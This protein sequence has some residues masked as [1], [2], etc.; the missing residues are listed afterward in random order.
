MSIALKEYRNMNSGGLK[1]SYWI[2]IWGTGCIVRLI[3][4]RFSVLHSRAFRTTSVLFTQ[5]SLS[6][7]G[8]KLSLL[9]CTISD[10]AIPYTI[11]SILYTIYSRRYTILYTI[12]SIL[13]TN[14][15]YYAMLC[16]A[17]PS[18]TRGHA[19][20]RQSCLCRGA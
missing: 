3:H 17:M 6:A 10:Y 15:I 19:G 20:P 13:Y 2:L 12:Y 8:A 7:K 18:S 11:Y 14:T 1:E 5:V 16:Y 4:G 9:Y